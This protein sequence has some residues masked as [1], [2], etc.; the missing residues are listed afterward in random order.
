MPTKQLYVF[1]A[2][3][4]ISALLLSDSTPRRAFDK[5]RTHGR[6]L[7]SEPVI[8]ELDD[9]LRRPRF[10]KYIHEDE[11]IRFLVA[12]LRDAHIVRVPPASMPVRHFCE[13]LWSGA[14]V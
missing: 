4:I 14:L 9:V 3:V 10:E 12:L 7:L 5:A 6:L 8:N 13:E 11:R 2:N 1:D